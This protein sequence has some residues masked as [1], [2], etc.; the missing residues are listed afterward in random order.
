MG[1][2]VV[3]IFY[4]DNYT[5]RTDESIALFEFVMYHGESRAIWD[6][7]FCNPQDVA[8]EIKE[9]PLRL[10][11]ND[12]FIPKLFQPNDSPNLVVNEEIFQIL[13]KTFHPWN[14]SPAVFE[15][16]YT[17]KWLEGTENQVY[18]P[19]KVK[20]LINEG[21]THH[22]SLLF[23]NNIYQKQTSENYFELLGTPYFAA[24]I[25][26]DPK[27]E[28]Y[29]GE[30]EWIN[31]R[32]YWQFC[33]DMFHIHPVINAGGIF[34]REDVFLILEPYLNKRYF[35]IKCFFI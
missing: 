20:N 10:I 30:I 1:W 4:L 28:I 6:W 34:V 18:L 12:F 7:R 35:N 13:K 27:V 3:K 11:R 17:L 23:Q 33:P 9:D 14:F 24:K 15:K 29:V 2:P 26:F 16:T 8:K 22:I 32:D 21:K 19:Q 31:Q 5:F 25:G